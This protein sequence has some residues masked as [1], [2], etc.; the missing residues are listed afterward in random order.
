MPVLST[1]QIR[2]RAAEAR[3]IARQCR[4]CPRECG[5]DR[6]AG[7]QGFCGAGSG[8]TIA[9]IV[10]HFGEEPPLT[11][12]GGAG[13]IFFSM[14]NLCCV[15]CQNYRISQEGHGQPV[16]VEDLAGEILGLQQRGCSTVEPVSP[17]HHLPAFL[18]A[19]ALA[20]ER[21]LT[22]PVVYNT[23]GFEATHTLELL[24]GIVDVYLP[25]LKYASD[26]A[27]VRFSGV[28][29]YVETA[30]KAVLAMHA[31]VGDIEVDSRGN[32]LRGLVL[33]H[34]VLPEDVSG[35][36]STL[37]WIAEDLPETVTLSLMAQY[38]PLYRAMQ[39]PP[40]DRRLTPREYDSAVDLAWD[41]GL[42]NVFV[43]ELASRDQGIP[44]FSRDDP[45]DWN[46]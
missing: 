7:E 43:Q 23:N 32:A 24:A 5:V 42:E 19:L 27:A 29:H 10:P 25:D 6:G 1:S 34:L 12:E 37:H 31:Q 9:S 28:D 33:R 13:T 36:Y 26:E 3:R 17:T 2:D 14:C 30:R 20:M 35:T 16:T 44:D 39:F 18:D 38:S 41:L 8:P 45:F 40:L 15:Y 46:P 4:M 21:G 22:L 11:G